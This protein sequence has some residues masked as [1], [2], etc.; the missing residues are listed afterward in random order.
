MMKNVYEQVEENIDN[1]VVNQADWT[2][3]ATA[4]ELESARNSRPILRFYD[5]EVPE[6]WIKIAYLQQIQ[7]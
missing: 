2:T 6:D 1:L 7:M 3:C 5:K 4:E